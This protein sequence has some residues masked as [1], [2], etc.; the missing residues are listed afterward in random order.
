[1]E[2]LPTEICLFVGRA[3]DTSPATCYQRMSNNREPDF[4]DQELLT[5]W[6]FAHGEGG[7]EKKRMYRLMKNYRHAW[8][9]RLPGYQTF[10]LRLNR[11]GPTFQTVK[12]KR[13]FK[14]RAKCAR[15][16]R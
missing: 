13:V 5:I 16:M 15:L 4:T 6:S 2:K 9:P 3:Y 14:E 8:F 12:R 7:S 11:L 10:V 1:M